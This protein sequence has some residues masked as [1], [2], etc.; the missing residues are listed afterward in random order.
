MSEF[1]LHDR[2]SADTH[3]MAESPHTR[4]LLMNNA[5]L[6]WFILVP[7]AQALEL[8]HLPAQERLAVREELDRLA[9][10]VE[11]EFAPDKLNIATLGNLVP[12]LHIHVVA[13]YRSDHAWPGPVWGRQDRQDYQPEEV[14][15]LRERVARCLRHGD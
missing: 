14:A 13:R 9:A 2:L 3:P 4:L 10:F 5:L 1:R 12:Q 8:H 6:P 11:Q 15:R 7:K